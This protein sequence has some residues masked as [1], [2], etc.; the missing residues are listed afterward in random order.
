MHD[1]HILVFFNIG[2]EYSEFF[3]IKLYE[4][5]VRMGLEKPGKFGN[6]GSIP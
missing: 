2:N 6:L 1:V 5:R 4:Y 3:I